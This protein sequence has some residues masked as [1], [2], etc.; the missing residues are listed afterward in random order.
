MTMDKFTNCD[1]GISHE[2][3]DKCTTCN[4]L[5]I[6]YW[7]NKYDGYLMDCVDCGCQWKLS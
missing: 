6:S 7:S 2:K 5:G 3:I 1:N 4:G